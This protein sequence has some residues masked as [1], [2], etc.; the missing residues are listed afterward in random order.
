MAAS[1]V[2]TAGS[3]KYK[4]A[5]DNPHHSNN[6]PG[7]VSVHGWWIKWSGT[8]PSTADIDVVLYAWFCD[9]DDN[10]GW[11]ALDSG[12][13]DVTAGGGSGRW[14]NARHPCAGSQNVSYL[15]RVDVDLNGVSDPSGYTYSEK[16]LDCYPA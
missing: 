10:C 15:G 9:E 1:A 7:D 6:P 16:V 13:A 5:V 8:C 4:Q 12:N 14:A 3:C 2:I 11:D